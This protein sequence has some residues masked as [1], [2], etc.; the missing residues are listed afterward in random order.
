[1]SERTPW[2]KVIGYVLA[3]AAM[4]AIGG[5][6]Y[7]EWTGYRAFNRDMFFLR[8]LVLGD[9]KKSAE[10]VWIEQD[11]KRRENL[12]KMEKA[13]AAREAAPAPTIETKP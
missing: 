6:G 5:R 2:W 4:A 11:K 1:M 7:V 9:P 8:A 13:K 3:G 10:S 12:E